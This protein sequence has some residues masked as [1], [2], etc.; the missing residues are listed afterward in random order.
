[1]TNLSTLIAGVVL[2][3]GI[4]L[5]PVLAAGF[6]QRLIDKLG[7]SAYRGVFALSILLS[8]VLIVIGWRSAPETYLYFLPAWSRSAG[9]VLMIVSFVLLGAA[10]YATRIKRFIRHPMLLGVFVW[11]LSHLL[12]N[13]STRAW[14]LFGGLGLWAMLEMALISKREGP[15]ELPAAPGLAAEL[16][17]L[18]I[19]AV[20]FAVVL[21]LHP[22]FSG[23]NVIPR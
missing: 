1:M 6:R 22:Y 13:G 23:V 8:T 3:C 9:F 4:H 5:M 18:A 14:V 2:W 17:G 21:F 11:S 20:V 15:R 10:N 7:S 16:K 12:T 19:S